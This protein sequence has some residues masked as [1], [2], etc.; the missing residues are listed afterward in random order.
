MHGPTPANQVWDSQGSSPGSCRTSN[1]TKRTQGWFVS[2]RKAQSQDNDEEN[3]EAVVNLL[4]HDPESSFLKLLPFIIDTGSHATLVPRYLLTRNAFRCELA[5]RQRHVPVRGITGHVLFGHKFDAQ[6]SIPP[7]SLGAAGFAFPTKVR[8]V[9]VERWEVDYAILGL[10]A[11]R[12]I[13]MVSDPSHICLW[14]LPL[15]PLP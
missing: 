6:L 2:Y 10:N 3:W 1:T 15:A 11:L 4:L 14:P 13:I 9:I 8:I 12:Q 5:I 7:P